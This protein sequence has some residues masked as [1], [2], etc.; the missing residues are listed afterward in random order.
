MNAL[1]EIDGVHVRTDVHGRYCLND[2]HRAAVLNK[3]AT[4]AQVPS[5]FLRAD[6]VKAFVAALDAEKTGE[7]Q[8]CTS[9]HSVKGGKNPGTYAEELVAIRYA[10]W[11][12][13]SFEVRV[14]RTFQRAA[15]G[16]VDWRDS[17]RHLSSATTVGR[18]L[19]KLVRADAGKETERHHY[20]NESRLVNWAAA[21]E[22][23]GIDRDSLSAGDLALLAHLASAA[24]VGP[25]RLCRARLQRAQLH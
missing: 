17:R 13:P 12:E 8:K 10:A 24:R 22:F 3:K 6:G 2:L 23:K 16:Q 5:Q 20:I 25:R 4:D 21:G 1:I 14:Y 11:I 9:V 19:L 18:D 7:V 15:K